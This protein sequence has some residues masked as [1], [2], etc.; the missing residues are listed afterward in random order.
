MLKEFSDIAPKALLAGIAV[1]GIINYAVIGPEVAARVVK[2]DLIPACETNIK[3]LIAKA[4]EAKLNAVKKPALNANDEFAMRRLDALRS[5]PLMNQ[6]RTMG[7][8]RSGLGGI[9]DLNGMADAASEQYHAARQAATDAYRN[10]L[11]AVKR[12]TATELGKAGDLCGCLADAA[13]SDTRTDWAIFSGTLGLVKPAP[14]KT[15]DAKMADKHRAGAC[16]SMKSGA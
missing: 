6:L 16:T 2:A 9:F 11:E 1:W 4:S 15:F 12:E 14:L 8:G 5:N 13:I 3:A 7:G 10:A